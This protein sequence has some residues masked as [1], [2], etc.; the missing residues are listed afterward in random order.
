MP[1]ISETFQDYESDMLGMIA[2]QWGIEDDI[3]PKKSIKKQLTHLLNNKVLFVEI[4]RSLPANTQSALKHVLSD[5]GKTPAAQFM[6]LFGEIREMGAGAREKERPDRNPI[7]TA[8]NLFYK[9]LIALS[10]FDR[11]NEAEEYIYLPEEFITFLESVQDPVLKTHTPPAYPERFLTK[12]ITASDEIL[13]H[14]CSFLAAFRGK[15]PVD[16]ISRAIPFPIQRFLNAYF[17]SKGIIGKK[18]VILDMN[19]LKVFLLAERAT[20]FSKACISW[21]TDASFNELNL[22][23]NLSF[24]GIWKNDPDKTRKNLIE[25]ISKLPPGTWYSFTD[26]IDWMQQTHP[27]FQR[28]RGEY[29]LWFIKDKET[30]KFINGYENWRQVEGKLL[31]YFLTGPLFWMGIIDLAS[32]DKSDHPTAFKKS[33][34]AKNLIEN[35]AVQYDFSETTE[36]VLH[37]NGE[38]LVP[39]N[40]QREIRYQIARFCVWREKLPNH[41]RYMLSS[42]AIKRA[43]AQNISAAQIKTLVEKYGRK[44]IPK[45]IPT[46]IDR[47][48]KHQSQIQVKE[49]I[50]LRVD[51]AEILDKVQKSPAK[52]YI[53]ERLNP[54]TAIVSSDNLHRLEDVLVKL[55]FFA[56]IW[57]EV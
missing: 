19:K 20:A 45:N 36:C 55:G 10:F 9:G 29:D 40:T 15:I 25:I 42:T 12:I 26:F 8:E 3:D 48:N 21:M 50:L 7:S 37:T 35:Q 16:E 1:T 22:L 18:A 31:E 47:W 57:H 11:K 27:D 14:M 44:P 52:Q 34:W 51:S 33:K 2:E 39:T 53:I 30:D 13:N 28:S 4:F 41:Y 46:A 17:F 5:G 24:E 54:T 32:N 23:S 43:A 38:I 6:R 56:D 49:Q